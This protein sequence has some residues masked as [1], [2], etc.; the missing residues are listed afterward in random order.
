MI[1]ITCNDL[2]SNKVRVKCNPDDK[3]GD[4]KKLIAFQ[5]R[6]RWK[7]IVLKNGHQIYKDHVTLEDYQINDGHNLELYYHKYYQYSTQQ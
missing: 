5:T 7:K 3:I 6:T 4:V 1:E 2:L